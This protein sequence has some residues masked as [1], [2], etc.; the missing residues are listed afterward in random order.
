M[1][2]SVYTAPSRDIPPLRRLRYERWLSIKELSEATGLSPNTIYRLETGGRTNPSKETLKILADV[3]G[4]TL[5]E[6]SEM[7]PP[8]PSPRKAIKEIRDDKGISGQRL[9]RMAEISYR[10]FLR[11]QRGEPVK[12][13]VIVRIADAL[14][15][16]PHVVAPDVFTPP[17]DPRSIAPPRIPHERAYGRDSNAEVT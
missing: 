11:A 17:L 16:P 5:G 2:I 7:V 1:L 14:K 3:Y 10:T 8:P 4:I 15:V 6:I 13:D 9:A 12:P